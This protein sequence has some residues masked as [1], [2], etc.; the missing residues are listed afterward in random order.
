MVPTMIATFK[1]GTGRSNSTQLL[2]T[3]F[4]PCK[5]SGGRR[6]RGG[7]S[8]D[9]RECVVVV[10]IVVVVVEVVVAI[11]V[12]GDESNGRAKT[13]VGR[14]VRPHQTMNSCCGVSQYFRWHKVIICNGPK[15]EISP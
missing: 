2:V 8:G 14:E 5:R 13:I 7:S 15:R 10:V 12:W 9:E 6:G 4:Q 11:R 3:T 1:L